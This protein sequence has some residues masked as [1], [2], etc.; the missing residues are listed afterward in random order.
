[1]MIGDRRTPTHES[2]TSLTRERGHRLLF[3][4]ETYAHTHANAQILSHILRTQL[5]FVM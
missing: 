2:G 1:M 5:I 4:D 3:S